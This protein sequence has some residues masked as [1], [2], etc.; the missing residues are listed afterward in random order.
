MDKFIEIVGAKSHNLKNI[1]CRI[2]RGKITVITGVSGSGKSTL[3]FDTLFAEGQRRYIESL[4]TYARQF[5]EKMDRP[6]VEAIHGIPPAIAIEQRNTVKNA[7]STVGTASEIYDY[8]RLLFAKIGEVF[9]PHCNV[10]VSGD[11]VDGVVEQILSRYPGKKIVV[12]SPLSLLGGTD[13]DSRVKDLVKNGYYRIWEKGEIIDLTALPS[14]QFQDPRSLSLLI[15]RVIAEE[16]NRSRLAEAVQRA[17]QLGDNRLEIIVEKG[18]K[19][20]FSRSFSCNHCGRVFSEPE[21]LLFSFNSPMGACATCQGFG[22]VIGID[23]EKVIPDPRKTLKQR[24]FAPWNSPGYEDL[25]DYLWK[26]C[27]R[28]RIPIQ[29][30][31]EDLSPSQKEILLKGK[32]EFIGLKGFFDWMEG[33]RYKVHYR[34]FL[35]KF[36]A[37]TPCPVCHNTR[38]KEEALHVRIADRNIAQLCEMSISD[39]QHL[40]RNLPVE[41]FQKEYRTPPPQGDERPNRVHGQCGPGI[42]NPFPT[43]PNPFERRISADYPCKGIG[44]RTHRNPLCIG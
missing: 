34:V 39:L 38:L 29:I 28:Y 13:F 2:P 26:A 19:T 18:E 8:L 12:I 20:T 41:E 24:P 30:P 37:Y 7:R 40:F 17:F 10:K 21:P 6:D 15:D 22:R 32:G 9:C 11:T 3:A 44:I 16:K 43:D 23:W 35:S 1:T 33:K 36:R 4:S 31:F 14:H 27:Q 25:Y 5:L 42:C